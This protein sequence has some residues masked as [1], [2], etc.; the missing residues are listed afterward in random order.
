[1]DLV[2]GPSPWNSA[3]R[4]IQYIYDFDSLTLYG[5]NDN[6]GF[7]QFDFICGGICPAFVTT[8]VI[9]DELYV[10][11]GIYAGF[12]T[13]ISVESALLF[14]T[15]TAYT[16]DQSGVDVKHM[17]I[18]EVQLWAGY[19]EF[20]SYYVQLPIHLVATFTPV[21]SPEIDIRFDVSG[22]LKSIFTIQAPTIGVDFSLFNRFRLYFN[23]DFQ[24]FYMVLNSSIPTEELNTVYLGTGVYLSSSTT[25]IIFQCGK[26]ILSLLDSTGVV[27]NTDVT[28]GDTG[29]DY[30]YPDY[31]ENDYL[32][33]E[34]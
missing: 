9:G 16:A 26:T 7:A 19:S 4:P 27:I 2:S 3:H 33:Q 17:L 6:G 32:T 34:S 5:V 12:H 1:M 30:F 29:A 25:Q 20:E 14:T 10:P 21:R 28:D 23:G 18:P 22:F 31:N 8:P 24:D 11:S 15:S 13:I